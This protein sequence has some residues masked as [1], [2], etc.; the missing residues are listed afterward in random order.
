MNKNTTLC[1][2]GSVYSKCSVWGHE[3]NPIICIKAC[4]VHEDLTLLMDFVAASYSIM[5]SFASLFPVL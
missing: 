3:E 1:S 4:T 2:M 5:S